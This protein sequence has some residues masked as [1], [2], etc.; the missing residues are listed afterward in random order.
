MDNGPHSIISLGRA[1]L[2]APGEVETKC[3]P[4]GCPDSE[5]SAKG[6]SEGGVRAGPACVQIAQSPPMISNDTGKLR[7]L[8]RAGGVS[9]VLRSPEDSCGWLRRERRWETYGAK[10]RRPCIQTGTK[11]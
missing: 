9:F 1:A 5:V 3:M 4:V 8:S 10:F 7:N 2:A 11:E 6:G